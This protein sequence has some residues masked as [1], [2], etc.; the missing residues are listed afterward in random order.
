MWFFL[1]SSKEQ[2]FTSTLFVPQHI[3]ST[4]YWKR[5]S[6]FEGI[7]KGILVYSSSQWKS[8]VYNFPDKSLALSSKFE[9][10]PKR[11]EIYL[12]NMLQSQLMR[13]NSLHL[14]SSLVSLKRNAHTPKGRKVVGFLSSSFNKKN[15]SV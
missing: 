6:G 9:N 12:K 7:L 14:Y 2:A 10:Q 3:V 13:I 15:T 4:I 11:Q 8:T 1:L 5:R